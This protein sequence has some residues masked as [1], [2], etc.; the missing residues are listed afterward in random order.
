MDGDGYDDIAAAV[1]TDKNKKE[2]SVIFWGGEDGFSEETKTLFETQSA[3]S[4]LIVDLG[5]DGENQLVV[6]QG[7]NSVML[8]TSSKILEFDRDREYRQTAEIKSEDAMRIVA[9]KTKAGKAKQLVVIN[10]EGGRMRG[11][12]DIYIFLGGEDGFDPQRRVELPGWAAVQGLMY[13][14]NDDG[15][16]DVM[17][18]NCAENAPHLDPGS[19]LYPG[20]SDGPD[21][22]KRIVIPTTRA[23]GT[24]VGD[25]RHS[26]Y[27]D[28][29][30]SGFA[31][32]QLLIFKCGEDGYDTQNPQKIVFGPDPEDYS[33]GKPKSEGDAYGEL[34]AGSS[35]TQT[36]YGQGRFLFAADFNGDGWLDIFVPQITGKQAFILWGGPD[37]FSTQRMQRLAAEGACNA[38]AADLTGNGYL[39]LV[40]SGHMATKKNETKESYLTIYWGGPDGYKENRKTQLPVYCSNANTIADFDGDGNLDIY[41]STYN[42]GRHRDILSQLYLGSS[43]GTFSI[44]RRQ[45]LFNHSGSGC[46]AGDFNGNGYTDLAVTCHKNHGDHHSTSLVYWG[47]PGGLSQDNVTK[48]PTLGP[49]GMCNVDPG[50]IMDRGDE[51]YYYSEIYEVPEGKTAAKAHWQAENAKRTWVNMHVRHAQT[52]EEITEKPWQGI[53][54][55]PIENGGDMTGLKIKGGFMQ[56]RLALGAKCFCGTPRVKSVT[57][58]FE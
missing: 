36:E 7:G 40:V 14:Y 45:E 12:E 9:G 8:S 57:I 44:K 15:Y 47:G 41:S 19:F 31:N 28:M 16:V 49:H 52:P 21:R 22:N 48:L 35:E 29:A 10:H 24:C 2:Q 34:F 54:G 17:V 6:C 13:D 32:R 55:K 11:D 23:H 18:T 46:L 50:N 30:V 43:D 38:N 37:G 1:C 26:G 51:E 39:D 20:G 58:E 4:M 3:Q 33:P 5:G 56:Y 53:G 27:L 25:F 42:S